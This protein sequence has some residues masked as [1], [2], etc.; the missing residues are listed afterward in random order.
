MSRP[1]SEYAGGQAR[2]PPFGCLTRVSC[3]LA[4]ARWYETG[5]SESDDV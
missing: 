4:T 1:E 5:G 3:F 2:Q